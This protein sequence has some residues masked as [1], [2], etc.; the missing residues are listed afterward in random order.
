MRYR[1]FEWRFCGLNPIFSLLSGKRAPRA[2]GLSTHPN[3][4]LRMPTFP[5]RF[6]GAPAPV[7]P[8]PL[9][10]EH[11]AQVFGDWL[12]MSAG[13]IATLRDEGVV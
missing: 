9:L 3:G 13:D 10:G 4:E 6:D 1:R 11:T 8:S 7:E 5:V 12:G 2:R